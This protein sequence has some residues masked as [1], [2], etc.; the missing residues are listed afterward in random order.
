MTL[1]KI[2]THPSSFL[3]NLSSEVKRKYIK[4]EEFQRFLDD[5]IETMKSA[6]GVGLAA[7]QVAKNLRVIIALDGE[8]PLV[9]I[10]PRMHF[11][12]WRK[13]SS[14][15]GCLSIPGAWGIVKRH[16]AVSVKAL[17]RRGEKTKFRARGLLSVIIQHEIDHLNGVLFIDKAKKFT[18]PPKM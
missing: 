17:N 5:M 9:L 1:L 14:E 11:K 4:T 7:P 2:V 12:S 3:R 8:K 10:N 13:I 6:Q 16:Y 18:N 15:E